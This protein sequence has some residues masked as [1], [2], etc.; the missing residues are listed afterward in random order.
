MTQGQLF[1]EPQPPLG[2]GQIGQCQRCAV[3]CRVRGTQTA[4]ARLLRYALTP[5]GLCVN[6]AMT[7]WLQ[8]TDGIKEQLANRKCRRCG[9]LQTSLGYFDRQCRCAQPDIP[10]VGEILRL[11]HIQALFRQLMAV[12]RADAQP[13]EI[14]W[15][16][17]IA[18]WDLPWPPKARRRRGKKRKDA[19]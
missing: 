7:E 19:P 3:R 2:G 14:D 5:E 6:C 10:G 8:T 9:G 12:G 4:D 13:D 15:D 1:H 11:P 18:N 17:V 16:E